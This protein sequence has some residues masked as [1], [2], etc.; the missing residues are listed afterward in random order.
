MVLLAA[1]EAGPR[2]DDCGRL[3]DFDLPSRPKLMMLRNF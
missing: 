3:W 1:L 2:G